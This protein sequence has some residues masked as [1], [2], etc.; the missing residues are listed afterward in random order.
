MKR[1]AQGIGYFF[2]FVFFLLAILPS[3]LSTQ[4]AKPL[5][6]KLIISLADLD[7]CQYEKLTLGWISECKIEGLHA[8][9]K[10]PPIAFSLEEA[11]T[12]KSL[13]SLVTHHFDL[14]DLSL[15]SLKVAYTIP[16][17]FSNVQPPDI[18]KLEPLSEQEVSAFL[19]EPFLQVEPEALLPE[20][21][22]ARLT[23]RNVSCEILD[24]KGQTLLLVRSPLSYFR[25]N[26]SLERVFAFKTEMTVWEGIEGSQGIV[27]AS[28]AHDQKTAFKGLCEID[29]PS[30]STNTV[31]TLLHSINPEEKKIFP[32]KELLGTSCAVKFLWHGNTKNESTGKVSVKSERLQMQSS[33]SFLENSDLVISS[34][35]LFTAEVTPQAFSQLL[36]Y[37][38]IHSP[39]FLQEPFSL[40]SEL[41]EP[42]AFNVKEGSMKH[43]CLFRLRSKDALWKCGSIPFFTKVDG[44]ASLIDQKIDGTFT[45]ALKKEKR[46]SEQTV[47]QVKLQTEKQ[48][49][50]ERRFSVLATIDGGFFSSFIE[51]PYARIGKAF[52]HSPFSLKAEMKGVRHASGHCDAEGEV[53]LSS[54]LG[55]SQSL[56]SINEK[57]LKISKSLSQFSFLPNLLSSQI[58]GPLY[59][60]QASLADVTLPFTEDYAAL[61][62]TLAGSTTLSFA[63]PSL[64]Y[65]GVKMVDA[66][67]ITLSLQK[68]E[69]DP[70]IQIQA[71]ARSNPSVNAASLIPLGMF[72][73]RLTLNSAFQMQTRTFSSQSMLQNENQQLEMSMDGVCDWVAKEFS[74]QLDVRDQN[75]N[76]LMASSGRVNKKWNMEGTLH[77]LPAF[78]SL[79]TP[80]KQSPLFTLAEGF[81]GAKA[82]IAIKDLRDPLSDGQASVSYTSSQIHLNSLVMCK[83]KEFRVQ[84]QEGSNPFLQ[85]T[86]NDDTLQGLKKWYN[87]PD[88]LHLVAPYTL[89]IPSCSIHGTLDSE[90]DGIS[91]LDGALLLTCDPILAKVHNK[92]YGLSGSALSIQIENARKAAISLKPVAAPNS[93]ARASAGGECTIEYKDPLHML[94]LENMAVKGSFGVHNFPSDLLEV[95]SPKLA[96]LGEIV[97]PEFSIDSA[98]SSDKLQTGTI[99]LQLKAPNAVFSIDSARIQNGIVTL[100]APVIARVVVEKKRGGELLKQLL[101]LL[102]SGPIKPQEIS[103]TI[104][105]EGTIIPLKNWSLASMSI[106]KLKL[107]IGK[108]EVKSSGLLE[109]ILKALRA[110]FKKTTSLWFTPIQGALQDGVLSLDRFDILASESVHLIVWGKA[111]LANSTLGM[112]VGIP[113]DTFKKLGLYMAIPRPLIVPIRGTFDDPEI[114]VLKITARIAGAGASTYGALETPLGIVGGALQIASTLGDEDI[115]IPPPAELPLPWEKK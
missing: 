28:L 103:L 42:C 11:K 45:L 67:S 35:P 16:N 94:T 7:E 70:T 87:M 95:I 105:P 9:V 110:S 64:S 97:S 74:L 107:E 96:S 114:N 5:V 27:R 63:A 90:H 34:G 72:P 73:K 108:I 25:G 39:L 15:R 22:T 89:S 69:S 50:E 85:F 66:L 53:R 55:N 6:T 115:P 21:Y 43:P 86:M 75:K 37:A 81:S 100:G 4:F 76:R 91:S 54:P 19:S 98:F 65:K 102:S 51:G 77:I 57:V 60:F 109:T 26:C 56:F 78:T 29:I 48:S 93:P 112:Y 49:Q 13:L 61:I 104:A 83:N 111:N 82:E 12:D 40:T 46:S 101:P 33:Y 62:G 99:H 106:P 17:S 32:L 8:R 41:K 30:L 10:K 71:E 58:S 88:S 38:E 36:Q 113:E 20:T 92:E 24:E 18:S 31:A 14:G 52:T 80:S 3:F 84:K 1:I 44:E 59:S 68:K 2:V 47:M 79:I 23:I